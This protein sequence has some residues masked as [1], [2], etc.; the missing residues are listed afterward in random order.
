[1]TGQRTEIFHEIFFN[2]TSEK[3]IQLSRGQKVMGLEYYSG[4]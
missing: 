4:L 1:M 2:S 3:V